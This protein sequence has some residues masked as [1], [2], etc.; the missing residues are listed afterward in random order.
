MGKML[1][2]A[3][4]LGCLT[5]V[6]IIAA[7][8][9]SRSP[10]LSPLEFRDQA[11]EVKVREFGGAKSD[12]LAVLA[13]YRGWEASKAG[14]GW[15]AHR[16]YCSDMFLSWRSLETMK[17]M[18]EEFRRLLREAGFIARGRRGGLQAAGAAAAAGGGE[19]W[20][21][22]QEGPDRSRGGG[23]VDPCDA[24]ADNLM[25]VRAVLVAGLY[26]NVVRVEHRSAKVVFKG[27]K[28][29]GKE[30]S[31]TRPKSPKLVAQVQ[32]PD[33]RAKERRVLIHPSSVNYDVKRYE[34]PWLVYGEAVESNNAIY[35][36]DSTM[37][38]PYPLLLFGGP[39]SVQLEGVAAAGA[40]GAGGCVCVGDWARLP[41]APKVGVLF[42]EL[43]AQ[44]D[45]VLQVGVDQGG[46]GLGFVSRRLV[47][48]GLRE[49]VWQERPRQGLHAGCGARGTGTR[50]S[51]WHRLE[52]ARCKVG[53]G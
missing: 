43:R 20:E 41:C 10:F 15:G 31:T 4:I 12:A 24:H 36:R 49:W 42:K 7:A 37:V 27:A 5:P 53:D 32:L 48:C 11:D 44:L 8:M 22:W 39:I 3:S 6:A 30:S 14:R 28:G 33:G 34:S 26:P 29:S 13:A 50:T 16:S 45:A 40:G 1:I 38:T 2:Y 19:G 23:W 46:V 9:S 35:L 47:G 51:Y 21:S 18:V 17:E 52:R 25:L